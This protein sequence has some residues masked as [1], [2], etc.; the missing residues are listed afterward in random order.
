MPSLAALR[1]N[2]VALLFDL[3]NFCKENFPTHPVEISLSYFREETK[4]LLEVLLFAINFFCRVKRKHQIYKDNTFLLNTKLSVELIDLQ[5]KLC[6]APVQTYDGLNIHSM[7]QST[8]VVH[9][10]EKT[11]S[12]SRSL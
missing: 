5:L 11:F 2:K 10:A 9:L 4:D 7:E 3:R 12:G 1:R 8:P 6:V